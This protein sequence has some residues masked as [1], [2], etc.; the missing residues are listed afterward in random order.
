[1]IIVFLLIVIN[2]S[3]TMDFVARLFGVENFNYFGSTSN[4]AGDVEVSSNVFNFISPEIATFILWG[5]VG[6]VTFI[7]INV[8]YTIFIHPLIND[9]VESTYVNS[10]KE[11]LLE[12]RVLWVVLVILSIVLLVLS[13]SLF[14]FVALP[15][16]IIM[17][18]EQN[19]ESVL[20]VVCVVFIC[21]LSVSLLKSTAE[22]IVKTY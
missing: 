2:F 11:L 18:N 17:L 4:Q 7:F 1:M 10:H 5:I 20:V 16:Y 22:A 14:I 3:Q 12:K 21:S 19:I 15:Y 6:L 13:I 9:I 8:I